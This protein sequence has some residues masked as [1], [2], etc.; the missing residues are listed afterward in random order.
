M[1]SQEDVEIPAKKEKELTRYLGIWLAAKKIRRSLKAKLKRE[2]IELANLIKKKEI[3]IEQA[4]YINN[5]I[6]LPRL[7]YKLR[8]AVVRLLIGSST[9]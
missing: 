6:L 2:S 8:A 3:S 9:R 5:K 4:K 1:L 7:D